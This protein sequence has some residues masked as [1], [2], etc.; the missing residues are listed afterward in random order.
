[1]ALVAAWG[2]RTVPALL[3]AGA[4]A[5]AL[6]ARRMSADL[7]PVWLELDGARLIVQMRRQRRAL[8]IAGAAARRLEPAEIGHLARLAT[9][10]GVTAGSGGFDS[11]L[12]GE[13]E[14]YASNLDNA[15]LVTQGESSAVVTPDEPER[16][17]AA[18]RAAGAGG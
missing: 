2:D 16:L 1:V 6:F 7:D 17:L 9:S 5:L 4:G 13:I 11:H 12:L 18:L 14:L 8:E 10:A 3:A 15:V